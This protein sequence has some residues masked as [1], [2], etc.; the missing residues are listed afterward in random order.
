MNPKEILKSWDEYFNNANLP[1]ILNL[2]DTRSI[3]IP[4]FSFEI[5]SDKWQIKEYFVKVIKE[6]KGSVE[7]QYNSIF[8]QKVGENIYLLN[9][10]YIFILKRKKNI[11]ARFTFL[12]NPLSGNPIKLHH[13][14]RIINN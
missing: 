6:Q 4:T 5:L 10:N 12:I 8:Q 9:V 2:H 14:S 1:C 7:I 3:L 11:P 13:S